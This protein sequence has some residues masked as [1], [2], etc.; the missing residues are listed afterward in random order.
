[1]EYDDWRAMILRFLRLIHHL[2]LWFIISDESNV[3]I[4]ESF[5]VD[6]GAHSN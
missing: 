5:S 1:M 2:R 4:G 6:G 3:I